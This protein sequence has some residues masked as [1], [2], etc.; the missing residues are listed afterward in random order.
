MSWREF[1]PE[2]LADQRNNPYVKSAATKMVLFT[3]EFKELF[4]SEYNP[5]KN[6]E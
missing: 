5:G 2:E 6:C 1:T 3:V 4:W